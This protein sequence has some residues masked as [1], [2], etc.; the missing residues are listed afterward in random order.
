MMKTNNVFHRIT[1]IV[2]VPVSFILNCMQTTLANVLLG[3]L[4]RSL[5]GDGYEVSYYA[6]L[7]VIICLYFFGVIPLSGFIMENNQ[8]KIAF[9]LRQ[10]IFTVYIQ[11]NKFLFVH[12]SEK[13]HSMIDDADNVLKLYGWDLA[14]LGQAIVAGIISFVLIYEVS[15]LIAFIAICY[16]LISIIFSAKI[17]KNIRKLSIS[18]RNKVIQRLGYIIDYLN[19]FLV[20]KI[21][22][23]TSYIY[24]SIYNMSNEILDITKEQARNANMLTMIS[25]FF[26]RVLLYPFLLIYGLFLIQQG[27]MSGGDL[28]FVLQLAGGITFFFGSIGNYVKNMQS[29]IISHRA[30]S[31]LDVSHARK[32]MRLTVATPSATIMKSPINILQ[33]KDV[34][35]SY[36]QAEVLIHNFNLTCHSGELICLSGDNGCGKSTLFKLILGLIQ[37]QSGNIIIN[38]SPIINGMPSEYRRSI[39]WVPQDVFIFSDTLEHN[40]ILGRHLGSLQISDL[41]EI[42]DIEIYDE[43]A[44]VK[45]VD[46]QIT[47]DSISSGQKRR[48]GLARALFTEPSLLLLDEYDANL[49]KGTY[50][51]TILHVRTRFPNTAIIMITHEKDIVGI[52]WDQIVQL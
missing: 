35:Y 40:I 18:R 45:S 38:G 46:T 50:V 48:V 23:K 16:G 34:C 26:S 52:K 43:N 9:Y 10:K 19:N 47:N 25:E 15:S 24:N 51:D 39:A 28:L 33:M 21:Y 1:E 3:V 30:I 41:L 29:S 7:V 13:L 5:F 2:L 37:P 11:D 4:Y 20:V 36:N 27:A 49:D 42:C 14:V 17:T 22:N 32:H 31:V 6:F 44:F 8:N 12:S